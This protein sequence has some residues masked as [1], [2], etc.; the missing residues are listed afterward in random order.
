M[1]LFIS[2]KGQSHGFLPQAR[3]SCPTDTRLGPFGFEGVRSSLAAAY[4]PELIGQGERILPTAIVQEFTMTSSGAFELM[5]EG[6]T[7]VVAEVRTLAGIVQIYR[8][9]FQL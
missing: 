8:Y 7:K 2:C 6:S 3:T 9:S 5:T 4:E 1:K